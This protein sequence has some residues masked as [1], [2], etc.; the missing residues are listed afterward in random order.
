M[1]SDRNE[2][3]VLIGTRWAW[4]SLIG[5]IVAL[6][7]V[8]S[9]VGVSSA[10]A[11]ENWTAQTSGTTNHLVGVAVDSAGNWTTVGNSGT[12]LTSPPPNQTVTFDANDGTGSM[13]PQVANVP[14]ALE[15]NT[16]TRAGYSF[17]GWNTLSNGSGTSYGDGATYPFRTT[18]TLYAQWIINT[19]SLSYN[20]N[21]NDAGTAPATQTGDYRTALTV[22]A[23]IGGLARNGYTFTGW[24]TAADGSGT[25]YVA[26]DTFTIPASDTALYARWTALRPT[27]T[28]TPTPRPATGLVVIGAAPK[29]KELQLQERTRLV[30]VRTDGRIKKV[31]VQC[32]LKGTRLR[33]DEKTENCGT[34]VKQRAQRAAVAATPNCGAGLKIKVAIVAKAPG[35]KRAKWKRTWRVRKDPSVACT[36]GGNG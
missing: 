17:S 3:L 29:G 27:P 15:S 1:R 12:I 22:E 7:L 21:G 23:N 30:K 13:S 11:N 31:K 4:R 18:E 33:G 26:G 9:L 36:L 8:L 25:A 10:R 24:N 6:A 19:Y 20:G 34:R 2:A 5:G 35:A 32:S 14:T 16:F 28:P